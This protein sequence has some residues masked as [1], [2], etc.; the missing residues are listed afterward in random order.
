VPGVT[1]FLIAAMP[2][3]FEY[4]YSDFFNG[5]NQSYAI[6]YD[7]SNFRD[8][9]KTLANLDASAASP[10]VYLAIG[11]HDRAAYW[12]FHTQ[13]LGNSLLAE[14]AVFVDPQSFLAGEVPE[15]SLIVLD[16]AR[17]VSPVSDQLEQCCRREAT[18]DSLPGESLLM[19]WR[20][21]EV[22]PK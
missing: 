7:P 9:T 13:K 19:I 14:K 16:V 10:A 8:L 1:L 15:K 22:G 20:R 12:T 2:P 21:I 4:F 6:R 11:P 5:Y 18:I 17:L 3:M